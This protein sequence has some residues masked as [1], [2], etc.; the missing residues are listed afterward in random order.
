MVSCDNIKMKKSFTNKLQDFFNS[1]V[2]IFIKKQKALPESSME[3][4]AEFEKIK[5]LYEELIKDDSFENLKKTYDNY[6]VGTNSSGKTV[7][8]EKVTGYVIED[9]KFVARVRFLSTWRKSAIGNRDTKDEEAAKEECFN[10]DSEKIY[11]EL[12]E[13]ISQQLKKTGNIDTLSVLNSLK[14]SEFKWARS[15]SRRLFRNEIQ[16]EIVTEYF[17]SLIPKVKKQTQKTL[18]TSQALYGL[19][20]EF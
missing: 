2:S 4:N 5:V 13:C 14:E 16:A 20:E 7:A 15:T 17:R 9:S 11:Y 1:I 8:V 12:N 3:T 18:T 19:E 6:T 10:S